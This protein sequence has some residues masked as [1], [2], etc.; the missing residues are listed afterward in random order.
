MIPNPDGAAVV[1]IR[2]RTK[3]KNGSV[4]RGFK[5]RDKVRHADYSTEMEEQSESIRTTPE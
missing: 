3:R 1:Q 4:D 2:E 5:M